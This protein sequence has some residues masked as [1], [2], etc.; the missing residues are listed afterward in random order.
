[1]K[2]GRLHA[3]SRRT[4]AVGRLIGYLY[5]D[6]E[7]SLTEAITLAFDLEAELLY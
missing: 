4:A 5:P 6:Q 2:M 7:P 3:E 1:M